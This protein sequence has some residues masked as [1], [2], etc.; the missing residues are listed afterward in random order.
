[1][2]VLSIILSIICVI[3]LGLS[4]YA[5]N[6]SRSC[7]R[8]KDDL[9]QVKAKRDKYEALANL[10]EEQ[11]K[12]LHEKLLQKEN[13]T[14]F[15]QG[16]QVQGEV[17]VRDVAAELNSLKEQKEIE[18][19]KVS[20]LAFTKYLFLQSLATSKEE[21][22][23]VANVTHGLENRNRELLEEQSTLQG[24]VK[25]LRN[26]LNRYLA[27]R[28]VVDK[29][30]NDVIWSPILKEKEAK[31]VGI[32]DELKDLYPDLAIDFANIEWKKIWMPQ[33][34]ELGSAID[35]V[36]GI[37]R[38]VLKGTKSW[39]VGID[40]HDAPILASYVGQAVDIKERWYQHVKKMVGV[41]SKGNERLY[42]YRPEDFD[43][44]IV[45]QGSNVDLN[46]SE[47]Y[48]IDYYCCTDALNKKR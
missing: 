5:F 28:E 29:S 1:M 16:Q 11:N 22:L 4:I 25:N 39:V 37:Y 12:D 42:N 13:E 27:I 6:L 38:L 34:Q 9:A 45:Q 44:C 20:G 46:E 48:W 14:G 40:P 17:Q 23:Q 24:D 47:K 35:K 8:I 19:L 15:A 2:I 7:R 18:A 26:E 31:L 21:Q 33:L 32:L 10:Y 43:W 3:L 41:M 30:I 36:R